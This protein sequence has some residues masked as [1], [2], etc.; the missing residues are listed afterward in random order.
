MNKLCIVL[1]LNVLALSAMAQEPAGKPEQPAVEPDAQAP[2]PPAPKAADKPAETLQDS[3]NVNLSGAEVDVQVIGNDKLIITGVEDDLGILQGMIQLIDEDVTPKDFRVLTLQNKNAKEIATVVQETMKELDAGR[4]PRPEEI[5]TVATV[6]S[7]ILVVTGPGEKLEMVDALVQMLDQVDPTLPKLEKMTFQLEHVK[8]IEAAEKLEEFIAVLQAQQGVEKGNEIK[9]F[10]I[11]V[12][13]SVVV[14][15]PEAEQAKVQELVNEIDVEPAKGFGDLHLAYY[16]LLHS[17]AKT[18]A[19]T[20]NELLT[21]EKGKEDAAE[22][23]RRIRMTVNDPTGDGQMTELPPINLER[24]VKLIPDKE[25]QALICVTAVENIEPLRQLIDL[26]DG[27]PLAVEQNLR[28]VPLVYADAESTKKLL[29]DMFQSGKK[30]PE[31]ADGGAKTS[32]VPANAVGESLVYNIGITADTR[33]NTLIVTGREHQLLLIDGVVKSIDVPSSDVKHPLRLIALTGADATQ[34]SKIIEEL[35]EKRIE[36][37]EKTGV[38]DAAIAREKIFLSV[39][40]HTNSLIV[41]ALEQNFEEITQLVS[42]LDIAPDLDS[43]VRIFTL[44]N[45]QAETVAEKIEKL[46]DKGLHTGLVSTDSKSS[47]D[48]Q[49][50][51]LMADGRSNSIVASASKAYLEIIEKLIRQMDTDDAPLID[52]DTRIFPLKHSDAIKLADMLDK[53]FE[54]MSKG[55]DKEFEAPTIVPESNS[56]ILIVTGSRDAIKRADSLIESLDQENQND[57]SI[58]VYALTHGSASKLTTKMQDVF[59]TREKGK[60]AERTPVFLMADEPTNSIICS[61]SQEDHGVVRHLLSLLDVPSTLSRRVRIFPL[62]Q[63]KADPTSQTLE[64]L[65]K[66]RSSGSGKSSQT[67]AISVQADKRT[68]SLVVWA[69]EA[70]MENIGSIIQKLDTSRPKTEMTVKVVTL[71]RA[72]ADELSETLLNTLNGGKKTGTGD[73]AEAVILTFDEVTDDGSVVTRKLLRQDITIEPDKRTNSLFVMAPSGSMEMLENLIKSIDAIPPTVAEIRLFPLANADAEEVV[74]RLQELFEEKR[75]EEGPETQ[76]Q[77]GD[78]IAT[79]AGAEGSVPGQVL[80]FSADRR[81]NM[82]IAAGSEADLNM[83]EDLVRSLDA[84]DVED[85]IRMIYEAKYVPAVDIAS[86]LKEYFE[87]ENDLLGELDDQ[88]AL[89]RQ[90]E[91]HV[92]VRGDDKSNSVLIGV[93]PRYYSRTMEMLYSIDRP[94][95]QVNIQVLIAEVALDDRLEFGMEFALQDLGFSSNATV[96]ANGVVNGHDFD[97]VGGTSVGAAGSFGGFTFSIT[98]EDFSFLLHALQ[99][100]GSLQVLSRPALMVENNEAANII[101]GDNVPF[102]RGTQVSDSGSTQSNIQYEK[103]GIKLHVTP[104]INPDGF[105]NLEIMPEISALNQGS[106]VTISEGVTAPTFQERSAETVVTVKDGETVVIGGLIQTQEDESESKVP[107][108]GD[109]PYVGNLFR[110]TQ[111]TRRR[112][113]LLMVLTVNVVR[114]EYQAR[115][116]SRK[117]R[118]QSGFLPE[119]MKRSPLMQGLRILPDEDLYSPDD[120]P[121]KYDYQKSLP[122]QNYGPSPELYGPVVPGSSP[123]DSDSPVLETY[124]PPAILPKSESLAMISEADGD[125]E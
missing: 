20:L 70:E 76:L 56:N 53:L 11:A 97:F 33:T 10:P 86:A 40:L 49:E 37:M 72:L 113:E 79:V 8:A 55:S 26:L 25:S 123:V 125:E 31:A 85:R 80:R 1:V 114:D 98:G 73:D 35:W 16:P 95:P 46:F 60:D 15:A 117:L 83:V 87:E 23:I 121:M 27:V 120:D 107:I 24:Q 21:T 92:T 62:Q 103:V 32:G 34:V 81:T 18:L 3:M 77:L 50:V 89:R 61:A 7:N 63:A 68:N 47:A 106:G 19:D 59:D 116:E 65:F 43:V 9:V 94:P 118:D 58:Q 12:S 78:A 111:S 52:N 5:I 115:V 22:T 13:N 54:G 88:S 38:G 14:F 69:A 66:S 108:F 109:I 110:S 17:E 96:G 64:E 30:L 100:D 51:A 36:S 57:S 39:D 48:K 102:L 93:S 119:R 2:A 99:S 101:I 74:T 82:V 45:A 112:T 75:T 42:R 124:G 71:K 90:A 29:D 4:E 91:R 104:H 105:V 6:A 84:Q 28:I 122:S 41:A 67:D 44:R